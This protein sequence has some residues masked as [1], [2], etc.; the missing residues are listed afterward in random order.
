MADSNDRSDPG[1]SRD[2]GATERLPVPE[3]VKAA[4]F[5]FEGD[6][7][8]KPVKPA[9]PSDRPREGEPGGAPCHA[10]TKGDTDYIWADDN[11]RVFAP[12]P[13]GVPIQVFLETRDHLDMDDLDDE[14]SAELGQLIVRLDRAIQAIGGVGRVHVSRWGDGASHFHMWFYARPL[15]AS[16]QLGFSLPM[17]AMTLPPTE[18]S[19]WDANKAIIAA[20]LA[21]GGGQAIFTG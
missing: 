5:P 12:E 1:S 9:F 4:I 11:W 2:A 19:I 21:A 7:Q 17:W 13:S 18:Q 20:E 14:R 10:C 15:G 8:V 3:F 6:L 16:Q